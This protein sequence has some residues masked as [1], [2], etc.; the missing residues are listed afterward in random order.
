MLLERLQKERITTWRDAQ[1]QYA[2]IARRAPQPTALRAVD[3]MAAIGV[4]AATG[5]TH[6]RLT[7]RR[8]AVGAARV[9]AE[10]PAATKSRAGR[11][12]VRPCGTRLK[13]CVHSLR[14]ATASRT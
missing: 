1:H 10:G 3:A 8:E 5:R 11:Q 6:P 12:P 14:S 4:T 7:P 9:A 2:A 13:K